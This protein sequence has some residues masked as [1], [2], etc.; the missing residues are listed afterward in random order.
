MNDTTFV[1][2]VEPTLELSAAVVEEVVNVLK[3]YAAVGKRFLRAAD[4]LREAGVTADML[5]NDKP[6]RAMFR[7]NVILLS[8]TKT[9]Q[10]IAAKLPTLLTEQERVTRMWIHRETGSRL[11]KVIKY[12]TRSE[13]NEQMTDEERGAQARSTLSSRLHKDLVKWIDKIEK[14]EA[15]DFSATLMIAKLKEAI[16]LIK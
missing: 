16:S 11:A 2:Q 3:E 6:F 9:E 15:V 5:R 1:Q 14:A 8:F 13:E 4:S 7:T 12:V 10:G